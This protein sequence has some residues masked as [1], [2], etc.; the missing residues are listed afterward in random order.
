MSSYYLALGDSLTAGYGVGIR[1]FA[2]LYYSYLRSFNP[3][4]H[5]VNYGINGLTTG[6]LAALLWS[7]SY[8]KSLVSQAE[9]ITL[10][11][12]SNDL[13]QVA[14]SILQGGKVN[15]SLILASLERNLD[16]IGSQIRHLNPR[17]LV[18][19][20]TLYN[21]LPAGPYYLYAAAGRGLIAQ[22]NEI[23]INWAKR[24]GFMVIPI[25]KAFRGRE[26]LVLG[27]DHLHPNQLG[28]R[29]IAEAFAENGRYATHVGQL[30]KSS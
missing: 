27:A 21:P 4:L 24:Y 1:N 22:A 16:L 23:I 14:K 7:N 3:Q 13:L 2:F 10:T 12:G 26:Q 19:V 25:D 5:Y 9:T 18:K 6:D 30:A 8:L 29:I 11:V 20:A 28:H 15:S 17:A